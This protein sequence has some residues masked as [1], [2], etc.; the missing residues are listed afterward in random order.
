MMDVLDEAR[1][2]R[3]DG[4]GVAI[5]TVVATWGSSPRPAGS[6]LIVDDKGQFVGSVSGGCIEGA[7]VEAALEVMGSGQPRLLE[8]GVTNE[9]AWEVGLACGGRVQVYVQ[10]LPDE[11]LLEGLA[12]SRAARKLV[13]LA[14]RLETGEQRVLLGDDAE[15]VAAESDQSRV[16]DGWFQ[17][18]FAPATRL[19]VV[20]AVHIAQSLA[21]MAALAGLE[22]TVVD[23]RRA[24]ATADRFPGVTLVTTQVERAFTDLEP[25][26]RTAVV[27]LT[28]DPKHDDKALS[29][30]LHSDAF[31]IGALG[32]KKTHAARL[33]RL[34]ELGFDDAALAR[35]HAPVGL[36]IGAR[37]TAEIAVSILAQVLQVLR[38]ADRRA[39]ADRGAAPEGAPGETGAAPRRSEPAAKR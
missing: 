33:G 10:K 28:H 30:A 36:D 32:S 38:N 16:D 15:A 27:T 25:D 2:W 37:S 19:M 39:E 4:K 3:A 29:A 23:P 1:S 9:R 6:Q 21:P 35:I 14:T 12:S 11:K 20:G 34:R 18:I 22:V 17:H 24:W 8:F 31:Y 26:R 7:V 13:V 5:A